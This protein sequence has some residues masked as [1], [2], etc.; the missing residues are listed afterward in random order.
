MKS[1]Y[2]GVL[3]V[4]LFAQM[5]SSEA[6]VTRRVLKIYGKG[7]EFATGIPMVGTIKN[8]TLHLRV[9][10]ERN[11]NDLKYLKFAI[12]AGLVVGL[13]AKYVFDNS[14]DKDRMNLL[15]TKGTSI[16]NEGVM[17]LNPDSRHSTFLA[18]RFK[19]VGKYLYVCNP[20]NS[21]QRCHQKLGLPTRSITLHGQPL[22]DNGWVL[23]SISINK[24]KYNLKDID[25]IKL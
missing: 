24:T 5:P 1:L 17:Y 19:T 25:Q 18:I 14:V 7:L 4:V 20:R 12:E 3:A 13:P 22:A 9:F 10:A 11:N 6:K 16:I 8:P 15:G 21:K 23:S 2:W